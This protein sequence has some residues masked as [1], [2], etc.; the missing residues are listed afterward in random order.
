LDV[1]QPGGTLELSGVSFSDFKNTRTISSATLTVYY[2]DELLPIPATLLAADISADD[3]SLNLSSAGGAQAQ[4]RIQIDSEVIQ[5]MA[6][7][8]GSLQYSI[9]RGADGSQASAHAKGS[10][11][12][13]LLA[14][15]YIAPFPREFFG[16]PYCGDWSFPIL[17]P[18]VRVASAELFVTNDHGA[19]PVSSICMTGT[20][21]NGM[22]T[23][24]GG[25]IDLT[26]DGVVAIASNAVPAVTLPQAR[27]I[28]DIFATAEQTP[29]GSNLSCVLNVSGTPIATLTIE[30][31]KYTSNAIDMTT[32]PSVWGL[33]IPASQPIMLDVIAVGS[34]YP[35]KRLTGTIRF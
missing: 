26:V 20:N 35:G 15:T 18:D 14:K 1:G 12:Y 16:S 8:T 28:R 5:V 29:V 3:Q 11:V 23:L 9:A 24:S 33:V 6:V 10:P 4:N 21:E 25:Q 22:R 34:S 32:N 27:S 2:W 7:G 13:Q 30:Q 17:M 31:G 19:S